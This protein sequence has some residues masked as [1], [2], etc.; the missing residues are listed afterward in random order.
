MFIEFI[1]AIFAGCTSDIE[2]FFVM[3]IIIFILELIG[4]TIRAL[5]GGAR[6]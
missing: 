6:H 1:N 2:K 3:V 5:T 4:D